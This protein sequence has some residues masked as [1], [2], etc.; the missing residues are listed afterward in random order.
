VAAHW[1]PVEE[2]HWQI[3][4]LAVPSAFGHICTSPQKS[5]LSEAFA[6]VMQ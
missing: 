4:V 2:A 1:L 5:M 6:D 3:I